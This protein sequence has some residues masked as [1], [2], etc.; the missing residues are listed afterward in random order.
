MPAS[1]SPRRLH[2]LDTVRGATLLSMIL[3]HASWDAVYLFGLPWAWYGSRG[4]FWWQQSICCTFILLSGFC[5]P[6]G[7]KPLRRGLVV[8]AAGL[9]V[10]AVT[11][12]F[13]YPTRVVFGV[14]TLL[15]SSMLLHTALQPV[16]KR[17][18]AGWGL[19]GSLFLFT[20]FRPVN[21][22][23]LLPAWFG[24]TIVLPKALYRGLAATFIG[25]T[26]PGFFSTDYFSLLPWY[27]LFAAGYFAA[28][29]WLPAL[30]QSRL[31]G[32][33]IAPLSW[34]GRHS[35]WIYL[36]HQPVIYGVLWAWFALN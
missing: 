22:G 18:P 27:F 30:R 28:R 24:N 15:G 9:A 34:L 32:L 25:F 14:L 17:V 19:T 7:R 1:S 4:A 29:L 6:L 5:W 16:L 13:S 26:D 10:T 3:Y 35:L 21:A 33:H 12:L 2:L 11:L 20:L 36:L 23:Y 31:A 8:F